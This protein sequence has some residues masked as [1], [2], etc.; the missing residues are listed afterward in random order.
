MV[1]IM[2]QN[3]ESRTNMVQVLP[4]VF[5]SM[6]SQ[7]PLPVTSVTHW[8]LRIQNKNEALFLLDLLE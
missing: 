5:S 3:I 7:S 2:T 6:Q 1:Q 4:D 8:P